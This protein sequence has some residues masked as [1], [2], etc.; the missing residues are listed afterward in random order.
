[1]APP[2]FPPLSRASERANSIRKWKEEEEEGRHL[3]RVPPYLL[4]YISC[5][6]SFPFRTLTF[7]FSSYFCCTEG[8]CAALFFPSFFSPGGEKALI[9]YNPR[10]RLSNLHFPHPKFSSPLFCAINYAF[11]GGEN[12]LVLRSIQTKKP[13]LKLPLQ[14]RR[15]KRVKRLFPVPLSSYLGRKKPVTFFVPPPPLSQKKKTPPRPCCGEW[16]GGGPPR[17]WWWV[18]VEFFIKSFFEG[19]RKNKSCPTTT[20]PLLPALR[21]LRDWRTV[22]SRP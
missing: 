18:G 11:F 17:L 9:N 12:A 16:G 8:R 10:R 6:P 5:W 22:L 3:L 20:A 2:Q 1:M 15:R 4:E 21:E 14:G 7:P 13:V 19:W